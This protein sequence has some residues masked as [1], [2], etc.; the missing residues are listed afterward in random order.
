MSTRKPL[1]VLCAAAA[2]VSLVLGATD[3]RAQRRECY[4][5]NVASTEL[6][7]GENCDS[8]A[9]TETVKKYRAFRIV[10]RYFKNNE[11][12]LEVSDLRGSGYYIRGGVLR[13]AYGQHSLACQYAGI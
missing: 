7:H 9:C 8:S 10:R 11:D 4:Y 5:V 3:S 6:Y 12:W 2:A 1:F 13:E